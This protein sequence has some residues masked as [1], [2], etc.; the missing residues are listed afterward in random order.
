VADDEAL[1]LRYGEKSVERQVT[2]STRI[3]ALRAMISRTL[4]VSVRKRRVRIFDGVEEGVGNGG[5]EVGEGDG[6]RD[7]GW[8]ISGRKGV[9]IVE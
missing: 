6:G 3:S 2:P 1:V 4:G 7:V 5:T 8:F 9:V